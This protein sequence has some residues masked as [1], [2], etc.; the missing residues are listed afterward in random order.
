MSRHI[1]CF[2]R[3]P[4]CSSLCTTCLFYM[5]SSFPSSIFHNIWWFIW[6]YD[7]VIVYLGGWEYII[8]VFT[9]SCSPWPKAKR[10]WK[11]REVHCDV[12]ICDTNNQEDRAWKRQHVHPTGM[13][14]TRHKGIK[15]AEKGEKKY[16]LQPSKADLFMSDSSS[17]DVSLPWQHVWRKGCA[18]NFTRRV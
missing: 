8:H 15:G 14:N 13:S 6:P 1:W 18:Q 17:E 10:F 7:S 2:I 12:V 16:R 3:G 9:Y 11:T 4:D 5:L